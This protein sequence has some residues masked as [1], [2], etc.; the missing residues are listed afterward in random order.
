MYA[1][2]R[3][4]EMSPGAIGGLVK[5]VS[6]EFADHIPEKVGSLLYTAIDTGDGTA[7]TVTFFPDEDAARRSAEAV[8]HVQKSLGD[9][10]VV[11][12]EVIQGRILVSRANEAV[13]DPVDPE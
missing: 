6:G 1:V 2:I 8:G 4:Y 13:V 9:F 12:K 7:A 3:R 5:R 11:E 10:G